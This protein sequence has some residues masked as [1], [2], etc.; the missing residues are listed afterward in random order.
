MKVIEKIEVN[1]FRSIYSSTLSKTNDLNIIIGGNDCGKSNFLRALNLFFNNDTDIDT[2]YSFKN[3]LCRIRE[4]EARATKGRAFLWIKITFLNYL[5]WNSLPDSF[6]IKKSWN[7]Y[8]HL[9]EINF[10][11]DLNQQTV[12][13]FLNNLNYQYIPAVRGRDMFSYFLGNLHDSLYEGERNN[14][15][16]SA[17]QLSDE[18]NKSTE[19]MSARIKDRLGFQSN[20]QAPN[21]LR[22]LFAAMD[23]STRFS[24]FDIPL[25]MRGDGIQARHIPFIL[26][27]I[28]KESKQTYIWGYEEPENS[29]ELSRSFDLADQF[30]EDFSKNNQLFVTT[31]SPAFYDIEGDNVNKYH[32]RSIDKDDSR[33]ISDIELINDTTDPDITLGVAALISDR[34]R[35]LYQRIETLNQKNKSLIDKLKEADLPLIVLEGDTDVIIIKNAFTTRLINN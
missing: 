12:S 16:E 28:S 7:R 8:S 22:T 10:S 11:R 17:K 20:I 15:N 24:N 27:F 26:D 34:A 2:P 30:K 18:I 33:R 32:V 31:H 23:F 19:T 3:D 21:D 5:N 29:L 6:Y 9:P 4:E 14:I 13:R 35:D 1:Y 25:Q